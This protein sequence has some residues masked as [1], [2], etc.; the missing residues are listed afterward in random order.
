MIKSIDVVCVKYQQVAL[1]WFQGLKLALLFMLL[2]SFTVGQTTF[3]LQEATRPVKVPF[4]YQNNFIILKVYMQ[5]LPLQFIVDTGAEHTILFQKEVSDLL[6]LEYERRVRLMGSDMSQ[7]VYGYTSSKVP[8]RLDAA[9]MVTTNLII[10]EDDFINLD[11]IAGVR[12]NGILGSNV[13]RDFVVTFDYQKSIMTISKPEHFKGPGKGYE[14][15]PISLIRNKPYVEANLKLAGQEMF[16]SNLLLDTGASLALLLYAS[17]TNKVVIPE[18]YISGKLGLGLGGELLGYMGRMEYLE[19]GSFRF[20]NMVSNFQDL[21]ELDTSF[22]R[23][24]RNGILGNVILGRF[25]FV[26]HYPESK[27]YLKPNKY[28]KKRIRND[29]SGLILLYSGDNLLDLVVL[30]VVSGSP[31]DLAGIQRGDKILKFQGL[32]ARFFSMDS[33]KEGKRIRLRIEREGEKVRKEFK[34]R[35]MI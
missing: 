21:S 28:F 34:L 30:D 31:A 8:I 20:D 25:S 14:E 11:Q 10:L 22:F 24:N 13:L 33:G 4:T 12:I 35:R 19:F 9:G 29:K 1:F 15:I 5:G 23:L 18:E 26:L 6:G 17:P 7:E 2:P 3:L 32:S 16:P 27:M